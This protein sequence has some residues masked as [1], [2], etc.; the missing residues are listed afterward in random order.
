MKNFLAILLL[1]A[2]SALGQTFPDKYHTYS[3]AISELDSL[4]SS[5]PAI[6]RLDSIGYSTRDSVV[7]WALKISDN[8]GAKE[9]EPAAFYCAGVHADEILGVE[10]A[11]G[12]AKDIVH[13]YNLGD[14]AAINYVNNIEIFVVPFINPEGHIVVEQGDLAWRKNKCDND[15]NGIFDYHDGVDNNRNYDFGWSIDTDPAATTPE[16]LMYKGAAPFTQTENIA[17]AAFAWEYRP[18][19]ALDYHSPT[20]G[21]SEV[22][23]YNWYWYPSDGGHGFAPDE[24]LMKQICDAYCLRIVNDAGDSC[25]EARRA[26]VNKGDFKTYFYGNF[27]TVSFSVEISDTTIQD[28]SLVDGVVARH[29]PGE[30]YLLQRIL[31]PGIT[32]IIRDSLTDLP[33][34]AEVQVLERINADINPRLSRPDFGRYRRVLAPGTYTLRFL[35]SGYETLTVSNVVV[36]N[37]PPTAVNVKLRPIG[38]PPPPAP[39]LAFPVDGAQFDTNHVKLAWRPAITATSYILELAQDSLFFSIFERDSTVVDTFYTNVIGFNEGKYYWRVTA[40]NSGGVSP[41]SAVR[42]FDILLYPETPLLVAPADGQTID[43]G[44]VDLLWRRSSRA[45]NYILEISADS[46]FA[47]VQIVDST[48]TDTN[49]IDAGPFA[50]GRYYWRVSARNLYGYSSRSATW[51]FVVTDSSISYVPGDVNGDFQVMGSDVTYLVRYFKGLGLPPP[52]EVNGFYPGADAN[53]D[54]Q[55]RGGD[56][57]Y[58]VAFFKGGPPPVDGHCF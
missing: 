23:Y 21:R 53:G 41:R 50:E 45:S 56:V 37:G 3:E 35:K 4:A 34:E 33:L 54:C 52:V 31:G 15:H 7:I 14:T 24:A 9:D 2:G 46:L 19:L 38:T 11:L 25:Y 1:L 51:D 20:Y 10:V 44:Y 58:L 32:G 57:T 12:F 8:V 29:L 13:K 43:T 16:S 30:Y 28:T 18:L 42:D 40:R 26:L 55:N 39:L 48:I 49:Y 22:A 6:C 47:T 5:N 17:I 27:G 36:I